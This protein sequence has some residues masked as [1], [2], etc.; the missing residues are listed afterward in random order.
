MEKRRRARTEVRTTPS[1]QKWEEE[2]ET[3]KCC[4]GGPFTE[5]RM[6]ISARRSN[7]SRKIMVL[8]LATG[9]ILT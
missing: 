8:D 2:V 6:F 9:D 1:S 7:E 5:D 3:E 4:H